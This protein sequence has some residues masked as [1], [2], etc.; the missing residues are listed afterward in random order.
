MTAAV[1]MLWF[2]CC[3]ECSA[4]SGWYIECR[5]SGCSSQSCSSKATVCWAPLHPSFQQVQLNAAASS[6]IIITVL[7]EPIFISWPVLLLESTCITTT[8]NKGSIQ[9]IDLTLTHYTLYHPVLLIPGS[10]PFH[11]NN[12]FFR[13]STADIHTQS[14]ILWRIS[15]IVW[16]RINSWILYE[17]LLFVI[18]WM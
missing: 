7:F 17:F 18:D 16:Q 15:F 6:R 3:W 5:M 9:C 10:N 1:Y 12:V 8:I 11:N 4:V 13:Y 2:C 14:T